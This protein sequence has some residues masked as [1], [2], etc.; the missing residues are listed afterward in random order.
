MA[1][2]IRTGDPHGFN[3]G[4]S[5]KFREGYRVWQTPEEGRRTY[6]PKRCGNNNKDEN[7]KLILCITSYSIKHQS[8]VYTNSCI[9]PC[10]VLPL[11]VKVMVIKGYSTFPK[12]QY[13]W[14]LMIRLFNLIS[15]T[16]VRESYPFVEMQS[17]YFTAPTNWVETNTDVENSQGMT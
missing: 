10:Q 5:S 7:K 9:W 12:L 11:Q 13:Y 2:G 17:E 14:N 4:R 1:N 6:R 8:F 15:R 3:K 16:V